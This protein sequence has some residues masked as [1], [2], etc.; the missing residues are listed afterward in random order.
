MEYREGE[1][2]SDIWHM[3]DASERAHVENECLKDIRAL[4]AISIRLDDPGK[5][6]VLYA[7]E[8]RA[9]TFLD[10]EVAA[11]LATNTFI[12]TSYEMKM[13]FN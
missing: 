8:S 10:F 11:P 3:L 7:R 13:I 9:V 12:P 2:L 4:R 5:H 1:R 6:D